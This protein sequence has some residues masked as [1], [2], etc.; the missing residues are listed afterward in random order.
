MKKMLRNT[1]VIMASVL[2]FL[3][4]A[5]QLSAQPTVQWAKKWGGTSSESVQSITTDV[6]GNI[7]AAGTFSSNPI[8]FDPGT[9]GANLTP[10]GPGGSNVFLSKFDASGNFQWVKQICPWNS[11]VNAVKLDAAGNIYIAGSYTGAGS[12][13]DFDPG[14]SVYPLSSTT[15]PSGSFAAFITKL[16]ASGNFVWAR[17]IGG[18]GSITIGGLALDGTGNVYYT[19]SFSGTV[20]FDPGTLIKNVAANTSGNFYLAK[21]D[22]SGNYAW[23]ESFTGMTGSAAAGNDVAVD[24]SGNLYATGLFSGSIY[25][26]PGSNTVSRTSA[27]STD[28]FVVK[29]DGSGT[30][31]WVNTVGAAGADQGKA[32]L[33]DASANIY[34]TG[35]FNNTVNFNP[36]GVAASLSSAGGNDVFVWRLDAAGNHTWVKGM[37]GTSSDAGNSISMDA[38]GNINIGGSFAGTA[39]FNPDPAVT[40]NLISAGSNDAFAAA[41]DSA[42]NYIWAEGYGG[43]MAD[44]ANSI[45]VDPVTGSVYLAGQFNGTAT[46]GT[47]PLVSAGST[48]AFLLKLVGILTSPITGSPFCAGS[49]VSVPFT[50]SGVFNSGNVFTAQ[51]SNASGSFASPV[52][53][54][55]LSSTATSGTISATIPTNTPAGTHYRIR[56]VSNN[57][58]LTGSANTIDITITN[59]VTPSF[60][61]V[62]PL[63]INAT[64]PVLPGTSNEGITG[65]WSP[66]TVSTATVGPASYSFTPNTGQCATG[67][68]LSITVND[69]ATIA[70]SSA[71]GTDAQTVCINHAIT[72]ITYAIGGSGSNASITSGSLPA[73]VTSSY[74]NGVFTI[75]GTPASSGNFS[76]TITATGSCGPATI[77]GTLAV[78]GDAT[79]ALGSATGTDGQTVCINQ[80]I[81]TITYNI[82]GTGGSASITSGTLPAGLTSGYA[83]GVF[84]IS[85]TPTAS[86]NFPYIITAT[87]GCGPATI[88][89]TLTVNPNATIALSSAAGTDGQTVCVNHAITTIA[90]AIAGSGSNAS[91][92]TGVLPAG[93]TSGFNNGVFT[94]SGT[95]TASGNFPYIITAT[96][97]CGPATI[98]GTLTVNPDATIA[99]SSAAGTD[100]Q[101]VC[102]NQPITTI[103]YNIGGTGSNASITTGVLPAGVTSGYNGNVFTI[104]GTPTASGNFPYIITATGGCGPAT[105]NGTLTVNADATIALSSAT[106]TDGQ[107]VCINQPITTITYTIGGTGSN[108]AITI[109]T[110]PAGVSGSY[111]NG[112]FTISGTPGATGNFPYTIAATGSCAPATIHGTLTVNAD[113]TI[114]RSS[115]AGTDAQTVCINHAIV[116]ITYAIG[117]SGSGAG[118]ISGSLPAGVT[119]NYSNGVFTISGTPTVSGSYAY[120]VGVTGSACNNPSL[121]GTLLVNP[122]PVVADITGPVTVCSGAAISLN[123]ITPQGVWNS[124]DPSKATIDNSGVVTAKAPGTVIIT[125]TVTNTCGSASNTTPFTV[126]ITGKPAVTPIVS[127]GNE[128]CAGNTL[129]LNDAT[130][131][132]VWSSSNTAIARISNSGVVTGVTGGTATI[133]Y[134]VSGTC[135][136]SSALYP[137]IIDAQP[138]LTVSADTTICTGGTATLTAGTDASATVQWSGNTGNPIVVTPVTNTSYTATATSNK[139][140]TSSAAV[141][142]TVED[143]SVTLSANPDPAIIGSPFTLTTSSALPYTITSWQPAYLFPNQT[144]MS[145]TLTADSTRQY[146]VTAR[147][148]AGCTDTDTIKVYATTNEY[149]VFVPNFFTPNNDGKNDV[150]YVKGTVITAMSFR[151]YNQW[152]TLV[153]ETNDQGQGWDGAYKGTQQ[154]VGVYVYV[155]RAN[156]KSG[157]VLNK[158]G[159]ITLIR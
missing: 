51:L 26:D 113:G 16:D 62:S 65:T 23:A 30:Y 39:D 96:G 82:G 18:P 69:N 47:I 86:G 61:A 37:G 49:P 44:A 84:T 33:L 140:C 20:D 117:G 111:N 80:P 4:F 34:V 24:A 104:S 89:G 17:S 109:G 87:G 121:P 152:G 81:T 7:Y 147:T 67:T 123:D 58:V 73:G 126:T 106:G 2:F 79:I 12:N 91:I 88:N 15:T 11:S 153:F 159:S 63:C 151:I 75:S 40:A 6:A 64:A 93:L 129:A 72:N 50:S 130:G 45:R 25:F 55:T 38:L 101:T 137:V 115:A 103:T 135:G 157:A 68:T 138:S 56:V 29:L 95:P 46:F 150:V 70:L 142:V 76:Y 36:S 119:G 99:L 112:V 118:I 53:I 158:K 42:G 92:T 14:P 3:F 60:T 116:N 54:G 124:S 21:L 66:A 90:Y 97:G 9:G 108:A 154:P 85:G 110:L 146:W 94:I 41:L 59:A 122:I 71:V 52:A 32:L 105:I 143:F 107:T 78:S 28:I 132:G 145:Q 156:L 10:M 155:L 139:G 43:T 141:L 98:S 77:S 48:D 127:T 5:V 133:S 74:N 31:T 27:G 19:G 13:I 136:D 149:D 8:D 134:T 83:G 100:G 1:R 148:P 144:A 120:T 114:V 57:I 128:T 131:N 22:A 102:I 35:I 125:Y